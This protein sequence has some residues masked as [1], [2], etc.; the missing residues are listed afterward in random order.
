MGLYMVAYVQELTGPFMSCLP[1][2]LAVLPVR[3]VL[4]SEAVCCALEK[5]RPAPPGKPSQTSKHTTQLNSTRQGCS[6]QGLQ[7]YI[8][9]RRSAAAVP[10]VN[11]RP[12]CELLATPPRRSPGADGR[13]VHKTLMPPPFEIHNDFHLPPRFPLFSPLFCKKRSGHDVA[14]LS[15]VHEEGPRPSPFFLA[16]EN[17]FPSCATFSSLTRL[18][19]NCV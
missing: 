1:P 2:P 7:G 13:Q 14:H 4:Y 3:R 18:D 17:K 16:E 15:E 8:G 12:S 9:A 11:C 5:L 19:D 6:L 10:S